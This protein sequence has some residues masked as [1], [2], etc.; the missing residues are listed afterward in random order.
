MCFV[1]RKSNPLL[2]HLNDKVLFAIHTDVNPAERGK[3]YS[4]GR[5]VTG[6]ILLQIRFIIFHR[7][8]RW[9]YILY[10]LKKC[11]DIFAFCYLIGLFILRLQITVL[12]G[13]YDMYG[14]DCSAA[15]S[16]YISSVQITDFLVT[17]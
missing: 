3:F 4:F 12:I 5:F 11:F 9:F 14:I 1:C 8:Q 2:C 15:S 13:W 10:Q 6:N 7:R 17:I 16:Q